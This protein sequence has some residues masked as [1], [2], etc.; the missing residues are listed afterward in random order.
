MS[1]KEKNIVVSLV[2]FSLIL[3]FY[4]FRLWQ[5][6][7]N[8]TFDTQHL[9]RLWGTVIFMAVIVTVL[10]IFAANIIPQMLAAAREGRETSDI[11]TL[12]DERDQLIDLRGTRVTYTVSSLGSFVAMLT[13]VFGQ[14]PLVMFALLIFFGVLAQIAGDISRLVRYRRGA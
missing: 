10:A 12:E 7:R 14:P 11:D 6:V 1:F 2:N 13:Y 9:F 8:D 3:A 4:L 5:F